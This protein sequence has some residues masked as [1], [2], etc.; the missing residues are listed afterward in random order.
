MP[1]SRF[2][3]L[4][5]DDDACGLRKSK[6][7]KNQCGLI[8]SES[9]QKNVQIRISEPDL[10]NNTT[11]PE[12]EMECSQLVNVAS[13]QLILN[14]LDAARENLSHALM[15][16]D[17]WLPRD[18]DI[19]VD[20]LRKLAGVE[21][22]L[23]G[24]KRAKDL[25]DRF[26]KVV[27]GRYG[28]SAETA[29]A[30]E[31]VAYAN[32]RLRWFG[33]ADIYY[34]K[35]MV[36]RKSVH[37][38]KDLQTATLLRKMGSLCFDKQEYK[39]A[40][41]H[42]KKAHSIRVAI[43]LTADAETARIFQQLGAVCCAVRRYKESEKHLKKSLRLYRKCKGADSLE[44][45]DT[46]C[47]LAKVFWATQKLD[48]AVRCLKAALT[49]QEAKLGDKDRMVKSTLAKLS[50]VYYGQGNLAKSGELSKLVM[51][52]GMRADGS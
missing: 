19:T 26:V 46:R 10:K 44:V 36:I 30:L 35:A 23:G 47:E 17:E 6:P 40:E 43:G 12:R 42:L 7:A 3:T 37:G 9:R 1:E 11:Y 50:G 33:W 34:Q 16:A 13:I 24:N 38:G 39:Q 41:L 22:Q 31:L 25:A 45:A 49:V 51:E 2:A 32:Q 18:G 15:V 27:Q 21:L 8:E 52:T 20:I 5:S 29:D 4:E 28:D 48:K 14:Q